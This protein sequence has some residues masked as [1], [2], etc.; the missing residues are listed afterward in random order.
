MEEHHQQHKAFN[1]VLSADE[2]GRPVDRMK[3][4]PTESEI[5][6]FPLIARIF[7]WI[8]IGLF[9]ASGIIMVFQRFV[10]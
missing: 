3:R 9:V 4:Y 7:F 2:L 5:S 6:Q 1:S 8:F 10:K